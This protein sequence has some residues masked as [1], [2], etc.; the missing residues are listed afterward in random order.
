LN[1]IVVF[2][3]LFKDKSLADLVAMGQAYHLDGYDLCVRPGYLVNPDNVLETLAPAVKTLSNAGLAVP[4]V[5]GSL[6]L[7][8][9]DQPTVE[10]ILKAM[11]Q[12]GIRLLKLGYFPFDP[13][14]QEYW[15]AVSKARQ[16]LARWEAL[17]KTY[18]V[19]ICYHTHARGFLGLNC[20]ALM[21]LLDGFNP[22]HMGAF[23]DPVH[24]VLEGEEF[25][26]GAAMVQRYLSIVSVKDVLLRRVD[27][28]GHSAV[29]FDVVP[30]GTGMVDFDS[31]FSTLRRIGFHG[32]LTVHCEFE[33]ASEADFPNLVKHEVGFAQRN[34]RGYLPR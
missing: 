23:I 32:P 17:G 19:K 30:C 12:A 16:A 21:H 24:L 33:S 25:P 11:D 4:M 29:E 27:T 31:V 18:Q 20:A 7:V 6:D 22:V 8:D 34:K 2:T 15:P 13:L 26:V 3:K 28:G 9:P 5:T 1:D 14:T 10:P